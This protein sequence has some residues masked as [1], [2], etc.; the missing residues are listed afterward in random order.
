[1]IAMTAIQIALISA[2]KTK[3]FT[4]LL[5][6]SCI[7]TGI[8]TGIHAGIHAGIYADNL[9]LSSVPHGSD[10]KKEK[11]K[12]QKA[13]STPFPYEKRE[14]CAEII[15]IMCIYGR[16][17]QIFHIYAV[18]NCKFLPYFSHISKYFVN[19]YRE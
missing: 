11:G 15:A 5:L 2:Y 12:R 13:K 17:R 7:Y 4:L 6:S 3:V 10:G 19:N 9:C 14:K 8:H 18:Q 16:K 1:M